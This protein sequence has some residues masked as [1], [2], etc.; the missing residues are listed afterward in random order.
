MWRFNNS[1]TSTITSLRITSTSV[2]HQQLRRVACVCAATSGG[3]DANANNADSAAEADSIISRE[4]RGVFSGSSVRLPADSELSY[5][6]RAAEAAEVY[7]FDVE[8]VAGPHLAAATRA[9]AIAAARSVFGAARVPVP[10]T[11]YRAALDATLPAVVF[12]YEA[13]ILARLLVDEGLVD[14]GDDEQEEEQQQQQQLEAKVVAALSSSASSAGAA[15]AGEQQQQQQQQQ[16]RQQQQQQPPRPPSNTRPLLPAEIVEHW[17]EVRATCLARWAREAGA[18]A[19][20]APAAA[21]IT[22]TTTADI[23][24]Q[25]RAAFLEAELAFEFPPALDPSS[26]SDNGS[27]SDGS[28]IARFGPRRASAAAAATA[29]AAAA[30]ATLARAVAEAPDLVYVLCAGHARRV[31]S[32]ALSRA[33]VGTGAGNRRGKARSAARRCVPVFAP[34][35]EAAAERALDLQ[36]QRDR[37]RFVFDRPSRAERVRAH[38][39]EVV[40]AAGG[41]EA[42]EGADSGGGGGSSSSSSSS[43]SG[44]LRPKHQQRVTVHVAEGTCAAASHR[45]AAAAAGTLLSEREMLEGMGVA[46]SPAVMDGVDWRR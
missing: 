38:L 17:D 33:G 7:A 6:F 23:D 31:A 11:A 16:Q 26:D 18:A 45:A 28:R 37:V 35:L 24:E 1:V 19:A 15:A 14:F 44:A 39:E 25:L 9:C 22:T 21:A 36:D 3:G 46:E 10:D 2:T 42:G 5:T 12:P 4:L 20:D 34:S 40:R 32:E 30:S 13:A 27:G 29:A 41:E 8:A 43:S